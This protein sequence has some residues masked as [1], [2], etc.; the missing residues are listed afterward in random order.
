MSMKPAL[1]R[2]RKPALMFAL[3]L[4]VPLVASPLAAGG[5]SKKLGGPVIAIRAGTV[6]TGTS[7]DAPDGYV[8]IRN[9][10]IE[11]LG[12]AEAPD[13]AWIV[14]APDGTLC[15]GLIDPVTSLGAADDLSEPA[16]ALTPRARA[17][18]SLHAEHSGF[19]KAAE[20]GV[21]L[22]GLSPTSDNLIGGRVSA[23]HTSGGDARASTALA[24][25]P[26]RLSLTRQ[27]F[28]YARTPTSRMG[29]LPMLHES[30]AGDLKDAGA[31]L[32][33][34]NSAD[35]IRLAIGLPDAPT[36]GLTLLRPYD[37]DELLDIV[38]DSGATAVL[39]PYGL[40]TSTRRLRLAKALRDH[41]VEIAFTG[42]GN[43]RALRLAAALA[44]REGL[45]EK[46]AIAA[47]TS[48]P[49]RILGLQDQVGLLQ[50]GKRADLVVFDGHP[51]D[52]SSSVQLCLVGGFPVH[53]A[54][55]E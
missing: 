12:V 43:P 24:S 42:S 28:P 15:P 44:M 26:L 4:V 39:G 53:V 1:S 30:L 19:R 51:L 20:G 35:E 8:V 3:L 29:A 17:S 18:E 33:E 5:G 52:L 46:D 22:V 34:A 10:R 13:G 41:N 40:S 36:R 37:A 38:R 11:G 48:V 2:W 27:A 54:D 55:D 32:V 21:T 31:L 45:S 49:A 23:V 6:L 16:R 25:G 7:A 47:V 14:D 9:G 50:P